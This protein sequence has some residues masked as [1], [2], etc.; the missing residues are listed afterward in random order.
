MYSSKHLFRLSLLTLLLWAAGGLAVLRAQQDPSF[1]HYWQM[2]TQFNPAAAGRTPQLNITAAL[3]THAMGYEDAGSTMYAGADMAFAI[4]KTRHGVGVLFQ[5]D[6]FGLFSHKR[7]SLQYAFHFKLWGGH[8]GIG[9]EV[10]M[11]NESINGSKVDLNDANDPAFPNTDL[12]G[13]KFDASVGLFYTHKRWYAGVAMQHVTAPTIY[14]G[15]T[16][17]Y[18]VKSVYNFTAGYNIRT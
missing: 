13:S 3:Q 12:S 14:M 15:E 7:F 17:E 16:N 10:D 11:L 1:V 4:K 8:L 18:K 6:E 9:A 5:N 2:E